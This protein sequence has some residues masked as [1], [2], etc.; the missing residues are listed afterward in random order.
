MSW[1]RWA[2]IKNQGMTP[3]RIARSKARVA[4]DALALRLRAVR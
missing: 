1:H 3:G 4:R 2:D